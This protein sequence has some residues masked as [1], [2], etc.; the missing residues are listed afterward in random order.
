[1]QLFTGQKNGYRSQRADVAGYLSLEAP[2][3]LS[4]CLPRRWE[5]ITAAVS[6]EPVPR[7]LVA[8]G[9]FPGPYDHH[10]LAGYGIE[11]DVDRR[12]SSYDV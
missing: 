7:V 6:F 5:R 4:S 10:Q 3:S 8:V 2:P 1:M 11:L 12:R 9:T